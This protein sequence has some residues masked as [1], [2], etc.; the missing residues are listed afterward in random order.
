MKSLSMLGLVAVLALTIAPVSAKTTSAQ[1][2]MPTCKG[3]VVVVN[4]TSKMYYPTTKMHVTSRKMM[5]MCEAAAKAKGYHMMRKSMMMKPH[6]NKMMMHPAVT[7]PVV[8]PSGALNADKGASPNP[9]N[10]QN[11]VHT[12]VAPNPTPT[13]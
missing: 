1:R 4:M 13:P 10:N 12:T 11:G 5:M 7:H 8:N 9:D 6:G 2:M 3:R